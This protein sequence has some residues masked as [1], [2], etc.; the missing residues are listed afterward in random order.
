VLL[1]FAMPYLD[2]PHHMNGRAVDSCI[3]FGRRRSF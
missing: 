1:P 2:V 3:G